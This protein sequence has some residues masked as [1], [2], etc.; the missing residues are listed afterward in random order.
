MRNDSNN[1]E[2]E[3]LIMICRILVMMEMN[4]YRIYKYQKQNGLSLQIRLLSQ[5]YRWCICICMFVSMYRN[6]LFSWLVK[7]SYDDSQQ[8][9]WNQFFLYIVVTFNKIDQNEIYLILILF[10]SFWTYIHVSYSACVCVWL[11]W[12]WSVKENKWTCISINLKRLFQL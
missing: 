4:N 1:N 11:M 10:H 12:S 6:K 3:T 7:F 2:G 5:I 8:L 9:C